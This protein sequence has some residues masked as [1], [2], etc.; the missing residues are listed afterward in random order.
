M[1]NY[2]REINLSSVSQ[3][4][5]ILITL[6]VLLHCYNINGVKTY[7]FNYIAQEYLSQVV[8][9]I[10]VPVYFF[11]SGYLFFSNLENINEWKN[12]VGRRIKTL[13]LPYIIWNLGYGLLLFFTPNSSIKFVNHVGFFEN[14]F[15]VLKQIFLTPAIN[16]FWFIRDLIFLQIFSLF[17]LIIKKQYLIYFMVMFGIL[18]LLKYTVP[19]I[20]VSTE[21]ILFFAMGSLKILPINYFQ[22]EKYIKIYLFIGI[23]I[24]NLVNHLLALKY[25]FFIHRI[26]TFTLALLFISF[27]L[28]S[29]QI[30]IPLLDKVNFYAFYIFALHFPI[31]QMLNKVMHLDNLLGYFFSFIISM[32]FSIIIGYF[33]SKFQVVSKLLTGNRL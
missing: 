12:K 29:N 14:F 27:F 18:F 10:A 16:P 26:C 17:F 9:R 24:L 23:S 1:A 25:E 31:I 8:S 4:R 11:I 13:L 33:L 22:K 19:F 5:F 15:I 28:N 32:T 3:V 6:I 30:K 7:Y 2:H 20:F 21:G